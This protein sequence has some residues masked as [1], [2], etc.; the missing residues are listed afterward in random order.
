M[1]VLFETSAEAHAYRPLTFSPHG[2]GDAS[3]VPPL[4]EPRGRRHCV[5]LHATPAPADVDLSELVAGAALL[6]FRPSPHQERFGRIVGAVGPD[7]LPAH[8]RM[9]KT[10]PRRSGKTEGLLALAV[11]RCATRADY[12]VAFSAQSGKKGRDRFLKMAVALDRWD[13]CARPSRTNPDGCSRDHVHR[14]IYRSNGG[15]RIEWANGSVFMVLPPDP[16]LYRGE[17]YHLI[18]LDEAQEIT[19]DEIASE[20]LGGINPTMDTVPEAQLIVAGTAGKVRAGLLWSSLEKGRAGTWAILEYAAPEHAEPVVID[21]ARPDDEPVL[22]VATLE[23]AHPG[24]GTL[25]TVEIIRGNFDDLSLVDYQREY[26]GQWPPDLSVSAIDPAHWTAAVADMPATRGARVGL[27]FDVAPDGSSASLACAWRDDDG[28]AYVELLAHRTGVSWL[29]AEAYR[30]ARDARV[31]IA[32]DVIGQNTNPADVISRRRPPVK[33]APMNMKDMQGAT[34]RFV[35]SLADGTV[36]HFDQKDLT[37]AAGGV[38]WRNV[39]GESA[40]LFGHKA[41]PVAITPLTAAALALWSY[42]KQTARRRRARP[43]V[44]PTET[45]GRAA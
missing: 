39:S 11:G 22:N 18:I 27:A 5:P 32:Y 3:P 33:L 42:D 28:H 44:R 19:D 30:V 1:N 37:I 2:G 40:R 9:A 41:S 29:P 36:H 7:G 25:T 17:E 4:R 12:Y 23:A 34:Q 20:L 16:E 21:P 45:K 43:P 24:V 38:G 26:L 35:S 8:R 10:E 6:G 14:R 13:P 15:E 31:A